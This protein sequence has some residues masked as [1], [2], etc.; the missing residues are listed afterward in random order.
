MP[1]WTCELFGSVLLLG[2]WLVND[3]VVPNV[4][5]SISDL[6]QVEE[7][8][9]TAMHFAEVDMRLF[10]LQNSFLTVSR[11]IIKS[12]PGLPGDV[13]QARA[14]LS[15]LNSHQE[16]VRTWGAV[17]PKGE[18]ERLMVGVAAARTIRY[19]CNDALV[20]YASEMES[21]IENCENWIEQVRPRLKAILAESDA[22]LSDARAQ[23]KHLE[24]IV[25][26]WQYGT[27][28]VQFAGMLLLVLKI[29][30]E[31][32]VATGFREQGSTTPLIESSS[33]G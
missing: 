28:V 33:T 11:G 20:E 32:S 12:S 9:R 13:E 24:R 16:L 14:I 3:A 7:E 15:L 21:L 10:Q 19:S 1:S 30:P 29:R 6:R 31:L 27:R 22:Q 23:R 26:W 4:Q 17:L 2:A 25:C 18:L 8:A 5:S